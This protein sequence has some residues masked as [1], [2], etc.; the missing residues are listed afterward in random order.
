VKTPISGYE[1][2]PLQS[3]EKA[4]EPVHQFIEDLEKH[5]SIVKKDCKNPSDGLT[6]DESASIKIF[7]MEMQETS[8]YRSLNEVLRSEERQRIKPWFPYL[9]L[10]MT[11]L[12]KVPSF[13]GVV[14]R[15]V[16]MDIADQYPKGQRGVWWSITSASPDG[17]VVQHFMSGSGKRTVFT[18]ECVNGKKTKSHSLFPKEDE[19]L[20]MPGFYY[21]VTTKFEPAPD[22][23]II[24]LKEI[25]APW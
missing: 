24:G 5:V 22:M 25:D 9:K 19:V 15:A 7:T 10:F 18:I 2:Q 16:S 1:K 21:E 6:P 17:S 4:L 13:K 12:H 23:H 11:A 20:L 14:W 8:L 3:L